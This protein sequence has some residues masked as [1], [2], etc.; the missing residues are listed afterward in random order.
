MNE[1]DKALEY[2]SKGR[3]GKI[4]VM[5]TKGYKTQEDLALAYTPGVAYPC[6]EIE[7]DNSKAYEY[8][9]K[10]NLVAIISNGTAVLGLGN[11]GPLAGKPVMEGKSLLFKTLA[12]VDAFDI[13]I[14]ETD[15]MKFVEV[16]RA[17]SPTFGAVNLEDIKS[18]ECFIIE[19][20]LKKILDIPVMHDDQHGTAI[21]VL[22][23]MINALE[24]VDKKIEEVKVVV[25]GAGAA[26]IAVTKLL[27]TMGMT[28]E[29]I[30][31]VD[32]RGVIRKDRVG[33][34][35]Y[36]SLFAT[37]RDI[38]TLKEAM[39][40]A[41]A[42]IGLS[43]P[44][45]ITAQEVDTMGEY[46]IIFALANPDPEI[47]PE[48]MA[49]SGKKVVYATGRSDYPNQVNNALA[50]PYL[51]HGALSVR[52]TEINDEMKLAASKAIASLAHEKVTREVLESYNL[53]NVSFGAGYLLP[54]VLDKRLKDVVS[55]A[56]ARAAIETGVS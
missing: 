23:A 50:F 26:A 5:P 53:E 43:K 37:Y 19:R 1:K 41:D 52:A 6:L 4:E 8:T 18:P 9:N 14:A 33:L 35:E 38:H 15:P 44:N 46:P 3:A 13:E 56:V 17:I 27:F 45:V 49:K 30:V 28:R 16:V 54:M 32:S 55:S 51:F 47:T 10:G 11:I 25:N 48:E 40:G 24:V 12:G 22:A 7:K 2:H 21:V 34:D 36:K 29:N 39:V 31:M 42:F 20:E